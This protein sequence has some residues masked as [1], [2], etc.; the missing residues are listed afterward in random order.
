MVMG[1]DS[2]PKVVGSNPSTIHWMDIFSY[3]FVVKIVNKIK[4]KRSALAHFYTTIVV[5][6]QGKILVELGTFH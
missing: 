1:R 2:R 4:E 6:D 5:S 3:I